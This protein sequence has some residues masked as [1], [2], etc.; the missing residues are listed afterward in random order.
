MSAEQVS[1]KYASL[2]NELEDLVVMRQ[3]LETQFQENRIVDDEFLRLK[4]ETQVYKL[5]GGVLLP[6]E[7]DEAKNNVQKRLEFI[8]GEI[9]RCEGNLKSKQ[10]ELESAKTELLKLRS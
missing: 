6:V 9:K 2:Q 4:P 5:T 1:Q 7:Q 8:E 3:K 10:M